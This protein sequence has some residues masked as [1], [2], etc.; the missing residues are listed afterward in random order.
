M[1]PDDRARRDELEL[2][3]VR[4]RDSK[5]TLNEDEYYQRLENLMLELA[6][7]YSTSSTNR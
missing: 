6:K 3:V 4:L 7:V 2:A 1:S 5:T